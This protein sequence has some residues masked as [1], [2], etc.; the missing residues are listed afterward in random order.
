MGDIS[1]SHYVSHIYKPVVNTAF[2]HLH[3]IP[4]MIEICTT[5]TYTT[6]HICNKYGKYTRMH[7]SKI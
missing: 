5:I 1:Y 6:H 3:I 2:I 4:N 7:S